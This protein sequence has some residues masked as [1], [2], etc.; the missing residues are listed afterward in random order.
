LLDKDIDIT[1][2]NILSEEIMKELVPKI[3]QGAKLKSNI[4]EWKK[5]NYFVK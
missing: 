3:G 5:V 4:D 2:L 1:S